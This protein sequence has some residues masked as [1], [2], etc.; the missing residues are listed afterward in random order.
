MLETQDAVNGAFA[1]CSNGT[2]QL[3]HESIYARCARGSALVTVGLRAGLGLGLLILFE[4]GDAVLAHVGDRF[5]R[6]FGTRRMW[7]TRDGTPSTP[8]L[9]RLLAETKESASVDA[10][11]GR[12]LAA[13]DPKSDPVLAVLAGGPPPPTPAQ[14][15][16][17]RL[18]CWMHMLFLRQHELSLPQLS[19]YA[20]QGRGV[21]FEV[22]SLLQHS[23]SDINQAVQSLLADEEN[24]VLAVKLLRV[25]TFKGTDAPL[26]AL[27]HFRTALLF[28]SLLVPYFQCEVLDLRASILDSLS[29]RAVGTPVCDHSY[30]HR[31]EVGECA[32]GT[33]GSLG[34]VG[35]EAVL[36]PD[37][38]SVQC[39]GVPHTVHTHAAPLITRG[40]MLPLEET[41]PF[42]I[43]SV[44]GQQ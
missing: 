12:M 30:A 29:K 35:G 1:E 9:T 41:L 42:Q 21:I 20:D 28:D 13:S 27:Q 7:L 40:F 44:A 16:C 18:Q 43:E 17:A 19:E 34:V 25:A 38:C 3:F 5:L 14:L 4:G 39:T 26:A 10:L 8:L 37:S 11:V 24:L 31:R 15:A 36:F 32:T 6:H 33:F 23:Q 2:V 22:K